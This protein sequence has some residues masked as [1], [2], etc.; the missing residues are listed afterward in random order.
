MRKSPKTDRHRWLLQPRLIVPR[1]SLRCCGTAPIST[2]RAKCRNRRNRPTAELKTV[3]ATTIR[4]RR[5]TTIKRL[6]RRRLEPRRPVDVAGSGAARAEARVREAAVA[7]PRQEEMDRAA[8]AARQ[9]KTATARRL[10]Q[11]L[12]RTS[13]PQLPHRL[14]KTTEMMRTVKGAEIPKV[15]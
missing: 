1:Q 8:N 10:L 9:V 6:E 5:L 15:G 11:P 14:R 2:L 13:R 7:R 3:R 12:Q 4:Q